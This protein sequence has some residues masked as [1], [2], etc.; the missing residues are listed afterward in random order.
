MGASDMRPRCVNGQRTWATQFVRAALVGATIV[1]TTLISP[2]T[3]LSAS[4]D[5]P[6]I[7]ESVRRGAK[8]LT[9]NLRVAEKMRPGYLA[10]CCYALLKVGVPA[11]DPGMQSALDLISKKSRKRRA[12]QTL[13]VPSLQLMAYT[14][15]NPEKYRGEIEPLLKKIIDL[16][17]PGGEWDYIPAMPSN[18]G[19]TSQ[20][21]YAM[22]ALWAADQAGFE[23]PLE[24]LERAAGWHLATQHAN[25]GFE[26]HPRGGKTHGVEPG[27]TVAG[28]ASVAIAR[29][30]IFP[31]SK[32]SVSGN[33]LADVRRTPKEAPAKRKFG[34]LKGV[35]LDTEELGDGA[36]DSEKS[37][38]DKPARDLA[39]DNAN[40][41]ASI[42]VGRY[43]Q[44][45]RG[46]TSWMSGH[47]SVSRSPRFH[48]Y[49]LYGL[50]RMAALLD[51]ESFGDHDWY[52]EGSQY[53]LGTQQSN[54]RWTG[55]SGEVPATAFAV[56]F[57]IRNTAKTLGQDTSAP[58]FAGGLYQGGRGLSDDLTDMIINEKGQAEE[59]KPKTP[60][61]DLLTSLSNARGADVWELQQAVVETFQIG[62]R[63]TLIGQKD[64]L[65][66]LATDRDPEIRRT[67]LWALAR[68][69]DVRLAPLMI[70]ALDD[71]NL[72]VVVEARNALCTLS[73]KPLG[74]GL[75]SAPTFEAG[76]RANSEQKAE[77]ADN[78]RK[79]ARE[80]WQAWYL[81]TRAYDERDDIDEIPNRIRKK[82]NRRR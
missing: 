66:K 24:A 74:F 28:A 77:A 16:Q 43:D 82:R 60:T 19:D 55:T 4:P 56:L 65:K 78:W 5:D 52:G 38:G 7:V 48:M 63:E 70:E 45:L 68:C 32:R 23:V 33:D 47:F 1:S 6:E 61:E 50:E 59:A 31:E 42:G 25:G 14:A 36:D 39:H 53:L 51:L 22:L 79:Q 30:Y 34:V 80:R 8:F 12:A 3:V 15:A 46:A 10:L 27:M 18:Q 49:Y 41:V 2:R 54:G 81:N 13:Y 20:S 11:D 64:L 75:P 21:Q 40:F 35:D 17:N 71:L 37:D 69:D 72:D 62:E 29:M 67:A 73:R 26:Y 58:T 44:S 57:L 76:E 9:E